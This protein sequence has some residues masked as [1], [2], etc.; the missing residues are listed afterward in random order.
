MGLGAGLTASEILAFY[1]K[2]G[3]IIFAGSGVLTW[4]KSFIAGKYS[5]DALRAALNE[6]FGEKLIGHS[7]TRLVIPS[8]NLETGEVHIF[9]TSHHQRFLV[10]YKVPMAE[11]AL[12]TAAAP[13]YFPT[14]KLPAGTSLID[15]GIWANNPAGVAAVEAI[16]VLGWKAGDVIMLSL[17]CTRNPLNASWAVSY[18]Q[19]KAYWGAKLINVLEAGQS[20]GATG[21]AHLLLGHDRVFRIDPVVSAGRFALDKHKD[22]E[23]LKGIGASEAR[24]AL[25]LP[26]LRQFFETTAEPFVPCH[27][28]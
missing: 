11:A 9:K 15:G 5:S 21:M 23:S 19:G 4:L 14:H 22:I 7:T 10:D 20:S 3:P 27:M 1:E 26:Q 2:K 25:P 18:S 12:A 8:Q 6:T 17:S 13:S 24:K 16:G 28:L